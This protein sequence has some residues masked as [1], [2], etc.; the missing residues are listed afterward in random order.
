MLGLDVRAAVLTGF[1]SREKYNSS[2]FFCVAFEHV[3]SL[4]PPGPCSLEPQPREFAERHVQVRVSGRTAQQEPDCA[5][6]SATSIHACGAAVPVA[7]TRPKHSA[8]PNPR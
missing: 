7:Q 1:V 4:L 2:R 3:S 8:R 5:S 6:R